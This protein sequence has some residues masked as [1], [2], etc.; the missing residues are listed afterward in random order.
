MSVSH[1]SWRGG[2]NFPPRLN[3]ETLEFTKGNEL[4][5][6]LYLPSYAA[7]AWYHKKLAPELEQNLGKTLEEVERWAS[8]DYLPSL[9]KDLEAGA[10]GWTKP[11]VAA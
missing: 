3:F 1:C 2:F 9:Q 6:V 10:E 7:T 11:G 5:Y 8:S 4:P